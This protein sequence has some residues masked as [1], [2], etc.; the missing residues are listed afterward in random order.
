MT[1]AVEQKGEPMSDREIKLKPCPFCG[2]KAKVGT[3]GYSYKV[4]CD[5]PSC[6]VRPNTRFHKTRENAIKAWNR[7]ANDER[8]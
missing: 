5:T 8:A 3:T 6:D 7:R 4:Y 1:F 2:G